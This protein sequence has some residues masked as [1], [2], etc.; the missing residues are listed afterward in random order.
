MK[1]PLFLLLAVPVLGIGMFGFSAF[2]HPQPA[3]AYV[4]CSTI[5]WENV[6][7]ASTAV[8]GGTLKAVLQGEYDNHYPTIYCGGVR[9]V[10]TITKPS[11]GSGTLTV[12]LYSTPNSTVTASVPA[13]STTKSAYTSSSGDNCGAV[14]V[15]FATSS[16]IVSHFCIS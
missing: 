1:K 7:S 9:G 15:T 14:T 4:Q 13:G 2:F 3:Q 16:A 8:S 5:R 12:S 10:G 11:G 6:S